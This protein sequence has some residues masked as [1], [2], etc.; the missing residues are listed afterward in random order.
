VG[1][2]VLSDPDAISCV[3]SF[4]A[5]IFYHITTVIVVIIYCLIFVLKSESQTVQR[6]PRSEVTHVKSNDYCV[7]VERNIVKSFG[8]VAV[9]CVLA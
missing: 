8:K 6:T 9:G 5:D 2:G 1:H 7:M 4:S 3:V